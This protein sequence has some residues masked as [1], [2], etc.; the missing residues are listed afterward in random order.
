[1]STEGRP[2]SG[3]DIRRS[4]ARSPSLRAMLDAIAPANARANLNARSSGAARQG[5]AAVSRDG[6]A[7]VS[8]LAPLAQDQPAAAVAEKAPEAASSAPRA[9]RMVRSLFLPGVLGVA[10]LALYLTADPG[11][12]ELSA[13]L[14]K[15]SQAT[16]AAVVAGRTS[17]IVVA[18]LAPDRVGRF[19][20]PQLAAMNRQVA[21]DAPAPALLAPP[22]SPALTTDAAL[23][24]PAASPPPQP[25]LR[26]AGLVEATP[27]ATVSFPL[28]IEGIEHVPPHAVL[29][30]KGV[31][32]LSG[33]SKGRP[34][35]PGTWTVDPRAASDIDLTFYA[36]PH[37]QA[38]VSVE[39]ID[40]NGRLIAE[41]Q[42]RIARAETATTVAAAAPEPVQRP[43][44]MQNSIVTTRMIQPA[45]APVEKPVARKTQTSTQASEHRA[46]TR[47]PKAVAVHTPPPR[48]APVA[49]AQAPAPTVAPGVLPPL[50]G[51]GP[52]PL[53]PPMPP[54]ST[55][56]AN[57]DATP[58]WAK[59][60]A[61]SAL[62]AVVSQ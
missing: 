10:V 41:A 31:P 36:M 13:V 16:T 46:R 59:P 6:A 35:E 5:E 9:R 23:A 28:R 40:P 34:I 58:A 1:M 62:G 49:A 21:T 52:T 3:I 29:V 25:R 43:A 27:G 33:L 17:P 44:P 2:H 11:R 48:P 7:R 53:L 4:E 55:A 60:W 26:L 61:R 30:I 24:Q 15:R 20:N 22:A 12:D 32:E 8:P 37:R 39:L 51:T 14:A 19:A 45:A 57:G 54:P 18:A 50:S 42:T 56:Q 38:E 47:R